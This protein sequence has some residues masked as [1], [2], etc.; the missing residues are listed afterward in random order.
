M[1]TKII[2]L[3]DAFID[4][5]IE[6]AKWPS[7]RYAQ[8]FKVPPSRM[9]KSYVYIIQINSQTFLSTKC[10]RVCREEFGLLEG[11]GGGAQLCYWCN[12]I[13]LMNAQDSVFLCTCDE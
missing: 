11:G 5:N 8:F 7:P 2:V 4:G 6:F 10:L 13:I 12:D 1:H 9:L 3:H